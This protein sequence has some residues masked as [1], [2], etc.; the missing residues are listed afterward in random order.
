MAKARNKDRGKFKVM[1]KW[2]G[3]RKTIPRGP[4]AAVYSTWGHC[5]YFIGCWVLRHSLGY[6][7]QCYIQERVN[8]WT[9]SGS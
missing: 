9:V 1:R 8:T 2:H 7:G 6:D 3:T 5:V 4:K